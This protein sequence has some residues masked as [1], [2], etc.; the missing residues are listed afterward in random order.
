MSI[1]KMAEAIKRLSGVDRKQAFQLAKLECKKIEPST[2]IK[3][4]NDYLSLRILNH[5]VV[6]EVPQSPRHRVSHKIIIYDL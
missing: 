4:D 5:W 6:E 3:L 1:N 2:I